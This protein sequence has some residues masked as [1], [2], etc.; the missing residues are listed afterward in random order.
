MKN[1]ILYN[2]FL[3]LLLVITFYVAISNSITDNQKI[4][5]L[6]NRLT[7]GSV[8]TL[9]LLAIISLTMTED[10][11]IGFILSIIYLLVLIR[12]NRVNENFRSGPSPLNC[13]TY[14][15]SRE[16]TGVAQYPLHDNRPD[17]IAC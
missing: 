16:K 12:V 10:L 2:T 13:S 5:S 1:N 9:L 14:G 6:L 15:N 17:D 4:N 8:N 7:S 11:Q 3:T